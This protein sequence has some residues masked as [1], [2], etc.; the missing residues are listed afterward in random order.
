MALAKTDPEKA[1]NNADNYSLYYCLTHDD[2]ST[3]YSI[4][5]NS[6]LQQQ[7]NKAAIFDANAEY[8]I[9]MQSCDNAKI[10]GLSSSDQKTILEVHKKICNNLL[11]VKSS[12]GDTDLYRKWFEKKAYTSTHSSKVKDTYQKVYNAMIKG[13]LTYADGSFFLLS[14]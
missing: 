7:S 2:S 12:V 10:I 6:L 5:T 13:T 3:V 9:R 11:K 1:I 8:D 14:I 4:N